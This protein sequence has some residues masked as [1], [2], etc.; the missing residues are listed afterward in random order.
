M[1]SVVCLVYGRV[2]SGIMCSEAVI[3][4]KRTP[5]RLIREPD[6]KRRDLD[7]PEG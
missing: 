3:M 4:G 6:A 5:D 2:I 1:D 7:E